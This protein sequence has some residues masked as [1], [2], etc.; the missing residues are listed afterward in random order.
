MF[1]FHRIILS[2]YCFFFFFCFDGRCNA[3]DILPAFVQTAVRVYFNHFSKDF[4]KKCGVDRY[5]KREISNFLYNIGLYLYEYLFSKLKIGIFSSFYNSFRPVFDYNVLSLKKYWQKLSWIF[6]FKGKKMYM[7]AF[8]IIWKDCLSKEY[9]A[10]IVDFYL[11]R[12]NKFV[13]M[14]LDFPLEK[15]ELNSKMIFFIEL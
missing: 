15:I 14:G 2:R 10:I 3:D 8:L 13:L 11:S 9:P 12:R 5:M 6:S 1:F 7:K 4:F